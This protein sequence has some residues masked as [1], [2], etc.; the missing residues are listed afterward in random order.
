MYIDLIIIVVL[1]GLVI[2]FFRKF[3]SFVYFMAILDIL[4]R[5]L[6]FLKNNLPLPDV[7]ALINKYVPESIP[8]LI[9]KYTNGSLKT[10]LVWAYV[11]IMIIFEV[12]II[13]YFWKKKRR[14]R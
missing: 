5:I 11:V 9:G 2:Y 14:R 13:K 8:S 4:L 1:L 10:V 3:D 12:Y 6:T 7:A